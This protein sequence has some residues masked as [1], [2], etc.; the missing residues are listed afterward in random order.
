MDQK[1]REFGKDCSDDPLFVTLVEQLHSLEPSADSAGY[2]GILNDK[3][4]NSEGALKTIKNQFHFK[5]IITR[6]QT[7]CIK[8]LLNL[9]MLEEEFLLEIML[10]K[11]YHSNHYWV[12]NLLI[13]NIYADR[14]WMAYTV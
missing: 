10:S 3:Q 9:K 14:Q 12:S 11:P 7:F 13:A 2:L 1:I 6:K 4:G 8:L 5:L